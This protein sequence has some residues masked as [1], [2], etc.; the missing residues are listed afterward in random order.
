MAVSVLSA[1]GVATAQ[2]AAAQPVMPMASSM[3]S[4]AVKPIGVT[5][6]PTGVTYRPGATYRYTPRQFNNAG[7]QLDAM[8]G[9]PMLSG[10]AFDSTAYA[11]IR[12]THTQAGQSE[13]WV[14]MYW[15]LNNWNPKLENKQCTV[16]VTVM[17]L[18]TANGP[19]AGAEAGWGPW[20]PSLNNQRITYY[21]KVI[22]PNHKTGLV[23]KSTWTGTVG[24]L[25][26]GGWAAAGGAVWA[27]STGA[28]Q[29]S[30]AIVCSSV[31]LQFS[32]AK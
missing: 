4:P 27:N 14:G 32:Q 2:K 11:S 15:T 5:Y 18:I 20:S 25:F 10:F 29:A 17:Y 3:A 6:A 12:A 9:T 31:V 13:A 28:G 1:A 19:N 7:T 26:S 16:T 23:T 24:Q 22:G 30:G 21:T 8:S